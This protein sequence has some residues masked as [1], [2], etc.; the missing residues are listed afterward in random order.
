MKDFIFKSSNPSPAD[1][2]NTDISDGKTTEYEAF[3]AIEA[4]RRVK[5]NETLT[6]FLRREE[7]RFDSGSKAIADHH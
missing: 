3:R 1:I 6:N 7:K 2:Y 4:L 5:N